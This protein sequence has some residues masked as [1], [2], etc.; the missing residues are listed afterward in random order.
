MMLIVSYKMVTNEIS[1]NTKYVPVL[2][3]AGIDVSRITI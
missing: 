3:S 2:V 1:N